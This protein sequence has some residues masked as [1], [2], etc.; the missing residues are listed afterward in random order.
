MYFS[1]GGLIWEN[2]VHT[3]L[4]ENFGT[5]QTLSHMYDVVPKWLKKCTVRALKCYLHLNLNHSVPNWTIFLA[6]SKQN[7]H[8][9]STRLYYCNKS[10]LRLHLNVLK[11]VGIWKYQQPIF[12][13]LE[14]AIGFVSQR[15]SYQDLPFFSMS[16]VSAKRLN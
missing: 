12:S 4:P 11:Y 13:E 9:F 2:S 16:L 10:K 8:P 15:S 14:R 5:L 1:R 7:M 6:N 3:V